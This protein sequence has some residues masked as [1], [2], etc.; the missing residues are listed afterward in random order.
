[1]PLTK[2]GKKVIKKMEEEYGKEKGRKV[3]YSS[4]NKGKKGSSKWHK[5]RKRSK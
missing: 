5:V 2:T 3:F 1:M 4:I